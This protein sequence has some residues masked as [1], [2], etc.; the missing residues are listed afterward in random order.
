MNAIWVCSARGMLSEVVVLVDAR[1]VTGG[2]GLGGKEWV[3]AEHL[4]RL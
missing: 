2:K 4:D 3:R 1:S